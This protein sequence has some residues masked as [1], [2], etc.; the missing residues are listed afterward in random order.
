MVQNDNN[1]CVREKLSQIKACNSEKTTKY[2]NTVVLLRVSQ[3]K[4][5]SYH[6][7]TPIQQY[8]LKESFT[9]YLPESFNSYVSI[10][11]FNDWIHRLISFALLQPIF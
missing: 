4:I 8:H 3:V 9:L 11:F 2:F 6:Q 5:F 1:S 10:K 7:L